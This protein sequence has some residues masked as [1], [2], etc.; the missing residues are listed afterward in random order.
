MPGNKPTPYGKNL[1][2]EWNTQYAEQIRFEESIPFRWIQD[3]VVV[4]DL[5]QGYITLE[6]VRPIAGKPDNPT[7]A[8]KGCDE[9]GQESSH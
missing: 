8:V 4:D 3:S 7:Q 1:F 5:K 6:E 2:H 9:E